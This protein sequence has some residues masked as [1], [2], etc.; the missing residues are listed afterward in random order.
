MNV[1]KEECLTLFLY[2]IS[3]KLLTPMESNSSIS[4]KNVSE[5]TLCENE[6]MQTGQIASQNSVYDYDVDECDQEYSSNVLFDPNLMQKAV[7]G[8]YLWM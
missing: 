5:G 8:K 4:N 7:L 2:Y 6:S 1:P 3:E